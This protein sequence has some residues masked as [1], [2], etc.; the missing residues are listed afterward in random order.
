MGMK[1]CTKCAAE[2]PLSEFFAR[3]GAKDGRRTD[4]KVCNMA[5]S[6]VWA[7]ANRE[8]SNAIKARYQEANPEKRAVTV[9]KWLAKPETKK[10]R[11]EYYKA[12]LE[13]TRH[14]RVASTLLYRAR[15]RAAPMSELDT[16]VLH[17]AVRLCRDRQRTV[18]GV[19][20]V[21]HI[22]PV[23]K[24]GTSQANNLQVVPALWNFRKNKHHS[25]RFLGV[26]NVR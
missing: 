19:W 22:V 16:F 1:T 5:K 20:H 13:R 24:G 26:Q 2:K 6:S 12:T 4:C 8:Q 21:D 25:G 14:R 9:E 23:A 18:G 10:H 3:K 17:E 15:L 7:A 11:A